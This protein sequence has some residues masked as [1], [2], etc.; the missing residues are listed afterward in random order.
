[1]ILAQGLRLKAFSLSE[2]NLLDLSDV[3]PEQWF[4]SQ[5]N[6]NFKNVALALP[7]GY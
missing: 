5:N 6:Y 3:S 4:W 7:Q 2:G 1:M